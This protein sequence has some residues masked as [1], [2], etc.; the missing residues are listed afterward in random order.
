M[1][2]TP[3]HTLIRNEEAKQAAKAQAEMYRGLEHKNLPPQEVVADPTLTA[4]LKKSADDRAMLS[5]NTTKDT[6]GWEYRMLTDGRIEIVSAPATSKKLKAGHILDPKQ[7]D[8]IQDPAQRQR[9]GTAYASILSKITTGQSIPEMQA[10]L[11]GG[12]KP[13][14]GGAAPAPAGGAPDPTML[15]MQ[16]TPEDAP[17]P[18]ISAVSPP[19]AAEI[20]KPGSSP[21]RLPNTKSFLNNFR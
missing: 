10:K 14:A 9:A 15:R 1:A 19:P 2:L 13:P 21:G 6:G 18:G 7:I 20:P 8:A 12:K 3:T 11:A 5:G 16:K 4:D 17:G